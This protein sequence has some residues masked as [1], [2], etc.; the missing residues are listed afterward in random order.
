MKDPDFAKHVVFAEIFAKETQTFI[1]KTFFGTL[2]SI[3]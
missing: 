2:K 3:F 1:A